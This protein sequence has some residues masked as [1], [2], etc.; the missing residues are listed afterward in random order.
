M[1]DFLKFR[2]VSISRIFF[3]GNWI[4]QKLTGEERKKYIWK[5]FCSHSVFIDVQIGESLILS[6]TRSTIKF[7]AIFFLFFSLD[8][9]TTLYYGII[10]FS[11]NNCLFFFINL[12]FHNPVFYNFFPI[13]Q[14]PANLF[15][16]WKKHCCSKVYYQTM[17]EIVK[18]KLNQ[19]WLAM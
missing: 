10:Q 17:M 18:K 5:D 2:Y 12:L 15:T 9:F 1:S 3:Y 8:F 7:L 6:D 16:I 19:H 11:A 13:V 14:R 4:S